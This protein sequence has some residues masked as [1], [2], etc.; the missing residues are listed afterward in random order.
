MEWLKSSYKINKFS[1][2]ISFTIFREV[3]LPDLFSTFNKSPVS[4]DKSKILG[5]FGLIDKLI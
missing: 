4:S 2:D 5:D 1:N 3:S